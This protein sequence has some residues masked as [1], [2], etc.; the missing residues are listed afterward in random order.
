MII[1]LCGSIRFLHLF[2]AWNE[3]LSCAGHAVF[4][5]GMR[6]RP[7]SRPTE[8]DKAV[9]DAVHKNKIAASDAVLVLNRFAYIGESTMSE[10]E[11]A[12]SLGREVRFLE[13]WGKGHGIDGLHTAEV[14]SLARFYGVP[15]RYGSPIDTCRFNCWPQD[16]FGFESAR[17]I[18]LVRR[19][20][21]AGMLRVG[22]RDAG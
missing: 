2:D 7:D 21:E 11:H 18:A 22:A 9:L 16:W 4:S 13:S 8:E 20:T 5:L 1:T 14:Q 12:K 6:S 19:V 15:E 3:A 10:I 17:R